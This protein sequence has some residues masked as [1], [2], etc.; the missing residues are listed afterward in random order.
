MI[1]ITENAE[2]FFSEIV[3]NKKNKLL[4]IYSKNIYTKD[5]SLQICYTDKKKKK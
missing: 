1:K 5:A 3:K 2:I 4:K